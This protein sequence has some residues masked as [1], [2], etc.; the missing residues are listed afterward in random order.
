[1]LNKLLNDKFLIQIFLLLMTV[2]YRFK[3]Y[4]RDLNALILIFFEI[5][6]YKTS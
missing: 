4:N 6:S 1:M 3:D 5:N 2:L